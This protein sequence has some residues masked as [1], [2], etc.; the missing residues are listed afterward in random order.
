MKENRVS[1]L[2]AFV[3]IACYVLVAG[4]AGAGEG[5]GSITL[6]ACVEKAVERNLVLIQST[7]TAEATSLQASIALKEML[8]TLSTT[9][10]YTG[11]RDASTVSILGQSFP[12]S[13]HDSY[14]WDVTLTQP[15]FH[16]GVL[17]NRYKIAQIDLDVSQL[18][19]E[20]VKNDLVRQ[21]KEAYYSILKTEMI[22]E[23]TNAAVQRLEAHLTDAKGFYEVGLI[24]KNDLLQSE[25]E[26]A[27]ARQTLVSASH[28]VE[29]AKARLNLL[30]RQDLDTALEPED[31]LAFTPCREGLDDLLA[32]AQRLRP[33]I[34]AGALAMEKTRK[35]LDVA[36]AGYWP[37]LDLSAVYSKVGTDPQMSKNPFGDRDMAQVLLTASWE[38]WAW[39]KTRDTAGAAAY[40]LSGAEA[41]LEDVRNAIAFDIK[42]AW[43]R[44]R[45]AAE[46][47]EVARASL[48]QA[49]E[50]FRLNTERYRE[51]LATSTD[52]LDAQALL[53]SAR[54]GYFNAMAD[55][56]IAKAVLDYAAGK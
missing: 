2:F 15:L 17:W 48:A 8:P 31:V 27:Q 22:K 12:V 36:R 51:R 45:E 46:N 41:A 9:Y 33:E 44:L 18:Q 23:E 20:Q 6:D 40:G 54:T 38:L 5:G 14:S 49:E 47:I 43:L 30:L 3:C 11:R 37:R 19:V 53:T 34:K 10:S 28:D 29:I 35:E 56:L 50:N 32:T 55:H 26:A 4:P 1:L 25:V 21:V 52:V 13:S 16:G 42:Q 39:G 7:L 24:A